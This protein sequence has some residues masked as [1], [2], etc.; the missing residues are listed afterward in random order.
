MWDSRLRGWRLQGVDA[1]I[2]PAGTGAGNTELHAWRKRWRPGLGVAAD[3]LTC[4]TWSQAGARVGQRCYDCPGEKPG[5]LA[6]LGASGATYAV[7]PDAVV[8]GLRG[9][10]V[11][12]T[13]CRD[14]EAP[15][16]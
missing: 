4:R 7:R 14:V 2:C 8:T 15:L 10:A 6:L 9:G 1:P 11:C 5:L 16:M 3:W 12:M 13:C